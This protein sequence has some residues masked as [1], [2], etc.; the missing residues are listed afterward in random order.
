MSN[1]TGMTDWDQLKTMLAKRQSESVGSKVDEQASPIESERTGWDRS[2]CRK[3][4]PV[5][6]G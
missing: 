2:G 4:D 5:A 3:A 1:L 6:D